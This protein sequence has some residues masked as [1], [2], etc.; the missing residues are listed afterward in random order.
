MAGID[1][2]NQFPNSK[3]A[4]A[5]KAGQSRFRSD[6]TVIVSGGGGGGAGTGLSSGVFTINT[7]GTKTTANLL[8][9]AGL[10]TGFTSLSI[11]INSSAS[12][13]TIAQG[14]GSA[15]YKQGAVI[16]FNNIS[17]T[18]NPITLTMATNDVVTCTYTGS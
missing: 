8:T 1:L 7:P 3:M 14:T 6:E 4:L 2:L 12:G 17:A 5:A 15:V 13:V 18:T 16:E 11:G 9:L 10:T